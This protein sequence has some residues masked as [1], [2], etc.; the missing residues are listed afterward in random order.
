VFADV[1]SQ[2]FFLASAFF[3]KWSSRPQRGV[4]G[5]I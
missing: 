4:E 5:E 1:E 3:L 2:V